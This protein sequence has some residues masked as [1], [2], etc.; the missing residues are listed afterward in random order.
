M[1]LFKAAVNNMSS[2]K[3]PNNL[4]RLYLIKA[5]A[6]ISINLEAALLVHGILDFFLSQLRLVQTKEEKEKIDK[7][8]IKPLQIS[9]SGQLVSIF[10]NSVLAWKRNEPLYST[11]FYPYS[12]F[13]FDLNYF[14][15]GPPSHWTK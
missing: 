3:P 4:P 14:A 10:L 7:H 12:I 15:A 11:P 6:H 5:P 13:F 2:N 1:N 9:L 8:C